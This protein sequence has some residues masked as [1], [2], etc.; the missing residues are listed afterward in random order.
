MI[1]NAPS[2][3]CTFRLAGHRYGVPVSQVQEVLRP[4][5]ITRLPHAAPAVRGLLHL[6]GAIITVIDLAQVMQLPTRDPSTQLHIVVRDGERPTSL[7]V[8]SLGDVQ[9]ID[10]DAIQPSPQTLP[11]AMRTLVAGVVPTDRELLLL[12]QFETLLQRA[13]DPQ[14]GPDRRQV[15]RECA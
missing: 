13:F 14:G 15:A 3:W 5:P 12:L 2:L 11:A 6:R 4:S 1:H 10:V 9:A 8:D 7:L